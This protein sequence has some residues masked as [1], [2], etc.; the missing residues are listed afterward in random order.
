M[1]RRRPS[2]EPLRGGEGNGPSRQGLE[3]KKEKKK[4]TREG[5]QKDTPSAIQKRKV[6]HQHPPRATDNQDPA[7]S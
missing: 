6:T 4:K 7:K 2:G 5:Y 1:E 3:A